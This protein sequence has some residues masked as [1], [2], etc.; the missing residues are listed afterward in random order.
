MMS[1]AAVATGKNA[2]DAR[3]SAIALTG[4]ASPPSGVS[5]PQRPVV[6]A[7]ELDPGAPEPPRPDRLR[8]SPRGGMILVPRPWSLGLSTLHLLSLGKFLAKVGFS[9]GRPFSR[10]GSHP[11][12]TIS[13]AD[14]PIPA[15]LWTARGAG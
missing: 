9:R 4:R 6:R 2:G 10:S 15:N 5:P 8:I 11:G 3:P 13:V 7:R 14:Y 1:A 12:S